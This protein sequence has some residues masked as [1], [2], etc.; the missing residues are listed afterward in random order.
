MNL[1]KMWE[2][3]AIFNKS[4]RKPEEEEEDEGADTEIE[5]RTIV[6]EEKKM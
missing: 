2:C 5:R 1:Q 6:N 3:E 4:E